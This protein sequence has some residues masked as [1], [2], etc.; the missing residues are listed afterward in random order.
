MSRPVIL[1]VSAD[2]D[3]C[4]GDAFVARRAGGMPLCAAT[5]ERALVLIM[6]MR[7]ALIVVDARLPDGSALDLIAALRAHPRLI[8]APAI[9]RGDLTPEEQRALSRD[10]QTVQR[11]I[12]DAE[13]LMAAVAGD[14]AWAN[15]LSTPGWTR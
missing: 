1:L 12:F 3:Q 2:S 5:L 11:P 10:P 8:E 14:V 4:D 7:P 9:V 6:K 15:G 13:A